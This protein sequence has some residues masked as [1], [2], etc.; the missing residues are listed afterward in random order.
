MTVH[1]QA[2]RVGEVGPY[3]PPTP[4]LHRDKPASGRKRH[5][6][7]PWVLGAVTVLLGGTALAF[8]LTASRAHEVSMR[9]A[10]SQLGAMGGKPGH[11]RPAPG[12]Y[13]YVGSG[14]E[15]LSLPPLSQSEG[16][17]IPGTVTL[18]GKNCWTWRIDYSSHHWQ[19]WHYC[20]HQGSMWEA[21][22]QSWQLW[23]IGPINATNLSSFT[24]VARSMALPA[25]GRP[26]QQWHSR[27]L[28]TNTSV[29]GKTVSAGPYK[30]LGYTTLTIGGVKVPAAHYL[31][32]RTDS[33][34]QTGTERSEEW[35]D[36]KTGL[37][38]RLD[39]SLKVTSATPF[40][41]STYTQRGTLQ[42]T[43]MTPHR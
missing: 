14:T 18:Q 28:G 27:C 3:E 38:L 30:L 20:V 34:A 16:P 6:R 39:Q 41:T 5:R 11:N 4:P 32:L 31:R 26:G 43:S 24:C 35:F 42:L 23:S 10:E 1:H 33:G 25:G 8:W 22:G 29:G 37:V 12:V 36:I 15:N 40:G 13:K 21:G 17:V 19:N 2:D 7:W 9:Q